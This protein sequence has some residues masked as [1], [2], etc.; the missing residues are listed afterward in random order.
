MRTAIALWTK[1]RV[2]RAAIAIAASHLTQLRRL[3]T[4]PIVRLH[5]PPA[6]R[7]LRKIYLSSSMH[8]A[9]YEVIEGSDRV[10]LCPQANLASAIAGVSMFQEE[11][12]VEIGLDVIT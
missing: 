11:R 6:R 3:T 2:A 10:G 9:H 5:I 12:T 1:L 8:L 4:V 7:S